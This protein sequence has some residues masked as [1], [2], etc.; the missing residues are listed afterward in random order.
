STMLYYVPI[1]GVRLRN[2]PFLKIF[3][4]SINWAVATVLLPIYSSDYIH[5]RMP[6]YFLMF[7]RFLFIFAI[8]IPFDIRDLDHDQANNLKTI[9]RVMGVQNA[10]I[11]SGFVL[12][13]YLVISFQNYGSGYVLLSRLIVSSIVL[14][15]LPLAQKDRS[16]YFYTGLLDGTMVLQGIFLWV[17]S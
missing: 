11:L 13:V 15:L 2:V 17:L 8:T 12:F 1:R 3:I 7:E 5:Q 14:L 4:I 10:L 9:P 6:V 16:G